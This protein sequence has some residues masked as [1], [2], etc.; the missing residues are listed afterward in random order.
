MCPAGFCL[1]LSWKCSYLVSLF[2]MNFYFWAYWICRFGCVSLLA[3]TTTTFRT[4][5][6]IGNPVRGQN[7]RLRKYPVPMVGPVLN[8]WEFR[9]PVLWT[10]SKQSMNCGLRSG[11]RYRMEGSPLDGVSRALWICLLEMKERWWYFLFSFPF[12]YSS[13]TQFFYAVVIL[14]DRS[15]YPTM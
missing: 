5:S 7:T 2:S 3:S 12:I 15:V 13:N 10:R 1:N 14:S 4:W 8:R 6:V 11:I 9:L